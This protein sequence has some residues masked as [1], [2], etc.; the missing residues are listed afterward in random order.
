MRVIAYQHNFVSLIKLPLAFC[1]MARNTLLITLSICVTH[2]SFE[3]VSCFRAKQHMKT[4]FLNQNYNVATSISKG[5]TRYKKNT[6]VAAF[7]G[8]LMEYWVAI[9]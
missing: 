8:P 6:S 2:V 7:R 3:T 4:V 5:Y 1:L 9:L